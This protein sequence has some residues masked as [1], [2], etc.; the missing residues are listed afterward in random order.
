MV[1]TAWDGGNHRPKEV[2]EKDPIPI[3][4]DTTRMITALRWAAK[5][6]FAVAETS[7]MNATK[8]PPGSILHGNTNQ[9]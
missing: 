4:T 9:V 6:P 1:L 8:T 3:N 7:R 5:R 2:G